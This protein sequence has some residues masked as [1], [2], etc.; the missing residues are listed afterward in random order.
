[1]GGAGAI[2]SGSGGQITGSIEIDVLF[3]DKF[4]REETSAG[5]ISITR[6][7]GF[8][9]ERPFFDIVSNTPGARVSAANP[10]SDPARLTAALRRTNADLARLLL[11]LV[12]G[13]QPG[14]PV[15]YT[16]AGQAQS[17][18]GTAHV[19][20]V[21]GPEDFK[22]RLFIDTATHVPLMLTYVDAEAR[23]IRMMQHAAPGAGGTGTVTR[24]AAGASRSSAE[25]A[26]D[27]ALANLTPEQRAEIDRQ[28][29]EAAAT[30]PTMVEYRMFFSDY[31]EV[32][33]IS[34]PHRIA[35]GTAEKTTEEWQIKDY[36]VN[37]TI[38]ADRFK[39]G[40][41]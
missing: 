4:Y 16:Y 5:G 3:P 36:R 13:T 41:D 9:G 22:A 6:I 33:G 21:A 23:P 29:K 25:G 12:A 19:I 30:P 31:R 38:K 40:T 39:M 18:D 24:G 17:P 27:P 8:E 28:I 15:T 1:M 35:R 34:L 10:A 11:G 32:S 7:D 26:K 14:L 2:G 20:D 37:P